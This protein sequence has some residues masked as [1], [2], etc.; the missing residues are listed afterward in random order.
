MICPGCQSSLTF[1]QVYYCKIYPCTWCDGIWLRADIFPRLASILAVDVE[2]SDHDYLKLF[3]PRKVT[4]PDS[5]KRPR[6]C[7]ECQAAMK[8]FNFAYDSNIFLDKCPQCGGIWTDAGEILKVAEHL[9]MDPRIYDV[10]Q[11]L[12]GEDDVTRDIRRVET[13]M[14]IVYTIVRGL[15]PS[16]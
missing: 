4:L 9:K 1:E 10:G 14:K 15:P 3:K 5:E 11:N 16:L 7:P 6:L 2:K 8:E 12:I 13:F